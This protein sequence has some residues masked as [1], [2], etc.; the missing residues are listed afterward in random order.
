MNA[1]PLAG[2]SPGSPTLWD[3]VSSAP[4]RLGNGTMRVVRGTKDLILSPFAD[5]EPQQPIWGQT[6]TIRKAR[7]DE[8]P[9]FF[10]SLFGS[11]P[12]PPPRTPRDFVRLPKPEF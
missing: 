1:K 4:Q 9:G 12:P 3:R 10:G 2:G 8:E 11:S 5:D 7:A 6:R